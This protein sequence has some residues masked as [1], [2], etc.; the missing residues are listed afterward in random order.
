MNIKSIKRRSTEL[1]ESQVKFAHFHKG[2]CTLKWQLLQNHCF[3]QF[4]ICNL[5]IVRVY[6]TPHTLLVEFC[7]QLMVTIPW[8]GPPSLIEFH[9]INNESVAQ[10][11]PNL[12]SMCKEAKGFNGYLISLLKLLKSKLTPQF[13]WI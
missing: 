6:P 13:P 7:V 12:K 1:V 3:I 4:F 10:C 8:A 9:I 11:L 2:S 5:H